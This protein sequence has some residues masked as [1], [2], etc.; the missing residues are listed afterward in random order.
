[1]R[2]EERGSESEC[3]VME[4]K[5]KKGERPSSKGI[6][7]DASLAK[8]AQAVEAK[9]QAPQPPS[10]ESGSPTAQRK[11]KKHRLSRSLNQNGM[12]TLPSRGRPKSTAATSFEFWHQI[13]RE[14]SL[15]ETALTTPASTVQYAQD[16]SGHLT[17][18][19]SKTS[20]RATLSLSD[21]KGSPSKRKLKGSEEITKKKTKLPATPEDGTEK[22][23]RPR[24]G[25]LGK[26]SFSL[27]AKIIINS[28]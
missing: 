16:D 15:Q 27:S 21:P 2:E 26:I 20:D 28:L 19:K 13:D 7:W 22:K 17:K 4:Q 1:M 10:T 18:R 25:S 23:S 9:G 12:M 24:P 14:A 3:S 8:D 11:K 6:I 5:K